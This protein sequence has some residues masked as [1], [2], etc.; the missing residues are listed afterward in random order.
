[1]WGAFGNVP[2]KLDPNPPRAFD[3]PGPPQ[4]GIVHAIKIS[5]DDL[6][7]VGDRGNSR[8][9][10]FTLDGKFV[11]QGFVARNA[12]SASTTG[13]LAFSPDPQQQFIFSASQGNNHVYIVYRQTLEEVGH[14]G[15][16]G[17]APGDF[18]AVHHLAADSQGNLYTVEVQGGERAQRFI[19]K[20]LKAKE[21]E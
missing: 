8:I 20:G 7:Y 14:F 19:Y 21:T 5:N 15:K 16:E 2:D 17:T 9:Q 10:V 12:K 11:K 4:F 3:G 13:G 6:I 1:M 18:R